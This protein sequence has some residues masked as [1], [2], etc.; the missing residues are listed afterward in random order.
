ML[1]DRGL[2]MSPLR[3]LVHSSGALLV[4]SFALVGCGVRTGLTIGEDGAVPFDGSLDGSLD[5]GRVDLG[6][7]DLGRVDAGRDLGVDASTPCTSDRECDDGLRCNGIERCGPGGRCLPDVVPEPC[8][9]GIA[10]TVDRCV[11]PYGTCDFSPDSSLCGGGYCDPR[12]GCIAVGCAPGSPACDDGLFCNG[13][14]SCSAD[15]VC[16]PGMPPC[17]MTPCGSSCDEAWDTCVSTSAPDADGDGYGSATCGG[18]DCDDGNPLVNP[19]MRERCANGIDD[20]CNGAI[21]CGDVRS[22]AMDPMCIPDAGRPDAGPI[23][24]GRPDAGR[25]DAGTP[26][27]G[28]PDSGTPDAGRPDAGRPDAGPID[29]GVCAAREIGI[30]ACT[31]GRDND[32]DTRTDCADPDCRPLGPTAE[33]CN[34]IDDDGDGQID[35]FTCR[36]FSNADCVGVGS[37]EQVCW[38][39]SYSVC[40]PRC[41][42][43]GGTTWCVELLGPGSRCDAASGE[44][45]AGGP[46]PPPP[47]PPPP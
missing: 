45:I 40:A 11:E 8:D 18:T 23:D 15:G 35:L 12:M 30:A 41:N 43:I 31:D 33:C 16:Q 19:G 44:C 27:A 37:L 17:P 22:C 21:D 24:A 26:D 47:P 38:L 5:L 13:R 4:L 29:I 14:E 32:C 42:F 1:F 25:P 9:D 3:F 7:V 46:P 34:G 28:R 10:C 39:R 2:P 6:R 20:D 36:C